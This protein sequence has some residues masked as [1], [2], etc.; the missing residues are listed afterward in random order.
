[1]H[2]RKITHREIDFAW[3]HVLLFSPVTLPNTQNGSASHV[4]RLSMPL[5]AFSH[6]VTNLLISS[7][8]LSHRVTSLFTA[9]EA[10][11]QRVMQHP[12]TK[13][14]LPYNK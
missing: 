4:T 9:R 5:E 11:S 13:E 8:A 3:Q 2:T 14:T 12:I 10:F 6:H 7:E 1:M